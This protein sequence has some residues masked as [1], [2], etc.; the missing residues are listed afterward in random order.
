MN[1]H[2][3]RLSFVLGPVCYCIKNNS[4]DLITSLAGFFVKHCHIFST[5]SMHSISF[6]L[7][8]PSRFVPSLICMIMLKQLHF[9]WVFDSFLKQTILRNLD[10]DFSI[11]FSKEF[12][13]IKRL[14]WFSNSANQY[15]YIQPPLTLYKCLWISNYVLFFPGAL[16]WVLERNLSNFFSS[17]CCKCLKQHRGVLLGN[18]C[19]KN[20]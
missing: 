1:Q 6:L 13:L 15:S 14:F 3:K 8:K 18:I 10:R 5:K 11:F 20:C 9:Q 2:R 12:K 19:F 16:K 4:K 17:L 7:Y